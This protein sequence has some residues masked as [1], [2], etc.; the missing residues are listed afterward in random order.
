MT[1]TDPIFKQILGDKWNELGK[2]IQDHY[3]LKPY[4]DNYICVTGEMDEIYHSN[5]AKLLIPFGLIF[6]AIVPYK[7]T[8]VPIEVH[9]NSN[10][11]NSKLYWDRIFKFKNRKAF[12]FKSVMEQQSE[13]EVIEFVRFGIGLKLALTVKNGALIF[14]DKGYVWR[15]FGIKIPIPINLLFGNAYI[16]ERPIDDTHFSMK[17]LIKHPLF[18]VLFRYSGLFTFTNNK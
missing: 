2:V 18:G 6:G 16:E 7:D 5:I 3:F 9:Y 1:N 12:H 17:M 14:N 10:P 13:N 15:L 11:D 8:N 4:S